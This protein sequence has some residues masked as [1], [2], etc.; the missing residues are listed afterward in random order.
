[1]VNRRTKEE[2]TVKVLKKGHEHKET[3]RFKK[4]TFNTEQQE[5][6]VQRNI[7]VFYLQSAYN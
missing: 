5:K 7:I 6:P 4:F 2:K 3:P 1:M